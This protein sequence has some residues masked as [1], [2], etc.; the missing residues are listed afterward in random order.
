M[1]IYCI[2]NSGAFYYKFT[3]LYMHM[4]IVFLIMNHQIMVI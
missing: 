3:Y 4:L 2:I 1:N